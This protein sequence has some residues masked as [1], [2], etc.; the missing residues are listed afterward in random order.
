MLDLSVAGTDK[1]WQDR[2]DPFLIK[3]IK[4]MED[5]ED[6]TL[7][8]DPEIEANLTKLAQVLDSPKDFQ[9]TNEEFY[10]NILISIKLSRSLRIMQH[11]DSI[12][13]GSASKLL[14]F[15][16]VASKGTDDTA[17]LFL[18]RNLVFE[19]LQLLSRI[20]APERFS[21]VTQ[22]VEKVVS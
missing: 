15:A 12:S 8:G 9:I 19:R 21:I 14:I 3:I 22:A 17:G 18:N 16:E 5:I 20:F 1:F 6:W 2:Q 4:T 11:I 13:P 10:I 7:D